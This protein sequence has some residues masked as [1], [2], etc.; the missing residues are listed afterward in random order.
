MVFSFRAGTSIKLANLTLDQYETQTIEQLCKL[1]SVSPIT[2][3]RFAIEK[4]N[5]ER[6]HIPRKIVERYA[7]LNWTLND[8]ELAKVLIEQRKGELSKRSISH[9]R[10]RIRQLRSL[11]GK[12]KSP[13]F[14]R[15]SEKN[16]K[17]S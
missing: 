8:T 5:T 7:Q 17:I 15:R 2:L 16:N 13:F 1:Y 3:Q 11:L 14:G 9:T 12:P 10:E 6:K 4:F